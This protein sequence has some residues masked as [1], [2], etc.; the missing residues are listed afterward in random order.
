MKKIRTSISQTQQKITDL[1][2]S[3]VSPSQLS[4]AIVLGFIC[5]LFP[6]PGTTTVPTLAFAF[7]FKLNTPIMMIINYLATPLNLLS[8]VYFIRVGEQLAG[9]ESVSLGDLKTALFND[10]IGG[11]QQFSFSLFLGIVAWMIFVPL[12]TLVLF[13][14]L[15]FVLQR[16][17]QKV[18]PKLEHSL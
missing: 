4:L 1:L 10:I 6:I 2:Y 13:F 5:G 12:A 3:G 14:P 11:I 8:F 17:S 7:A 16:A 18:H 15:K 9:V